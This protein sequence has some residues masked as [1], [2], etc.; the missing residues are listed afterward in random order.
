MPLCASSLLSL[1]RRQGVSR[2]PTPR[3]L[4]VDDWSFRRLQAGTLLVDLER[5]RPVDVLQQA[6]EEIK[7]SNQD[8][9]TAPAQLTQVGTKQRK[10][11]RRQSPSPSPQR[12]WQL[13]LSQRVEEGVR[14]EKELEQVKV[15]NHEGHSPQGGDPEVR[16]LPHR[17]MRSHN[18]PSAHRMA[19]T[20][21]L[22]RME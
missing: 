3:V 10:P 22:H 21:V 17:E 4:G 14:W 19:E 20:C 8:Q 9:P 13:A 18:Q 1:L 5:H 15:R 16:T 11:P 2:V 12:A 7:G 6:G